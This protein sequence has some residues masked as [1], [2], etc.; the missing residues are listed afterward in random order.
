MDLSRQAQVTEVFL[1][2][3]PYWR[4]LAQS[5]GW[6]FGQKRVGSGKEERYE[7]REVQ[8]LENMEW[9]GAAG[10]VAEF[11]VESVRMEGAQLAAY[12]P[13]ALHA[14]GLVFEPTGSETEAQERA[15]R[16]WSN[17]ALTKASLNRVGQAFLRFLRHTLAL[18]YYPL[19]VARYTYRQRA[20]QVVVDGASGQVLY[21]KAPGNIYFRAL[22]L[23]GGTALGSFVVVDGL[24]LALA[25]LGNSNSS[26]GDSSLW[27]LAIPLVAGAALIGGGYRLFRWG[28]EVETRIKGEVEAPTSPSSSAGDVVNVIRELSGW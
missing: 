2:Y 25:I 22:M 12:A 23:L 15:R 4:A 24:A 27:L 3:L 13:E 6:F 1:V 26:H 16:I 9:T 28:E 19:W 11:G 7:P 10:D 17:R 5:A 21:G 8:I 18:V 20:Y 14:D